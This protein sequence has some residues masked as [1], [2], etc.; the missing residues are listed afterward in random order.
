[1]EEG[2]RAE[3]EG[4]VSVIR[5]FIGSVGFCPVDMDGVDMVR[6]SLLSYRCHSVLGPHVG[7]EKVLLR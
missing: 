1:V 5:M 3:R 4:G 2:I 7:V 6:I